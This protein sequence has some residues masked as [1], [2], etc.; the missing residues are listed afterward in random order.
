M[1]FF[2]LSYLSKLWCVSQFNTRPVGGV[3]VKQISAPAVYIYKWPFLI[4]FAEICIKQMDI[5]QKHLCI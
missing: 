2:P 1:L 4:F 3:M 5:C